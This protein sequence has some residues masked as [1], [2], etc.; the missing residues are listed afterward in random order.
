MQ[1]GVKH[2]VVA[3]G[4]VAAWVVLL[5]VTA[6]RHGLVAQADM[7]IIFIVPLLFA[8][9]VLGR[10]GIWATMASYLP[11]LALGTWVDAKSAAG[12]LAMD[13]ALSTVAQPTLA[14]LIVALILDRLASKMERGKRLNRDLAAICARLEDEIR[15]HQRSHM[16]LVHSQR[17]DA[18]GRLASSV[19][20][21]FSNLLAVILGYVH[22]VERVAGDN[23]ELRGFLDDMK[24]V[25]RRGQELNS[26]LLTLARSDELDIET[27]DAGEVVERLQPLLQR[28]FAPGV[29]LQMERATGAAPVRLDRA[30]FEAVL[31]NMAKNADDA[32]GGSGEFRL[33]T[34]VAGDEVC[35]LVED[36]GRGMSAETAARAFEPFF[37][38]KPRGQGTG[39]GLATAYRVVTEAGGRIDIESAPGEGTRFKITLPVVHG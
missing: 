24:R 29:V 34:Q 17:V 27:F 39:I 6:W 10:T 30:G 4:L 32:L 26:K 8:G 23:S 12:G 31:L 2:R 18:L 28:M 7:A 25:T 20:H 36:T 37:S 35:V 3:I 5:G 38:T 22:H 15:E 16:Q 9:L 11:I 19:A 21:D 33:R 13:Q 14:S 1:L